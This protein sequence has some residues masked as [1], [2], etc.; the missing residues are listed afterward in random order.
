MDVAADWADRVTLSNE[1]VS[2]S[3][4]AFKEEEG[5]DVNNFSD[6]EIV[7]SANKSLHDFLSTSEWWAARNDASVSW[8]G[9]CTFSAKA[10][11]TKHLDFPILSPPKKMQVTFGKK[12]L[13]SAWNSILRTPRLVKRRVRSFSADFSPTF[14][15]E[16]ESRQSESNNS[17]VLRRFLDQVSRADLKVGEETLFNDFGEFRHYLSEKAV[18]NKVNRGAGKEMVDVSPSVFRFGGV[19]E[20]TT[21]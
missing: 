15:H 7:Y 21:S 8:D 13:I 3:P 17:D 11:T 9:H 4:T 5:D 6:R 19:G 10:E 18:Y 1:K 14:S 2:T 20:A 16:S 12:E